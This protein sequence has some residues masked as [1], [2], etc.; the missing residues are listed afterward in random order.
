MST[1]AHRF[2]RKQLQQ[3]VHTVYVYTGAS[4]D[5]EIKWYG[6]SMVLLRA[7]RQV[8]QYPP[9]WIGRPARNLIQVIVQHPSK[10]IRG[11]QAQMIT[12]D[13]VQP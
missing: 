11:K 2:R 12:F 5:V 4:C 1:L 10:H 6:R 3:I 13:E 9:M 8:R 7:T